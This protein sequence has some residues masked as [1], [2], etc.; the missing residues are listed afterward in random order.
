MPSQSLGAAAIYKI[1]LRA[2]THYQPPS[3][4][5]RERDHIGNRRMYRGRFQNCKLETVQRA[6][7]IPSNDGSAHSQAAD[8]LLQNSVL[9]SAKMPIQRRTGPGSGRFAC[10]WKIIG[11]VR[12]FVYRSFDTGSAPALKPAKVGPR[13]VR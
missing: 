13:A 12:A 4:G 1:Q 7:A 2:E 6:T 5:F 10:I 11:S 8:E 3:I 9:Q